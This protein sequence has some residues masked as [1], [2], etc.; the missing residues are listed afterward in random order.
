MVWSFTYEH[1]HVLPPITPHRTFDI[2][3]SFCP[4]SLTGSQ[5]WEPQPKQLA[6]HTGSDTSFSFFLKM[7]CV[8]SHPWAQ[9]I[10]FLH[11]FHKTLTLPWLGAPSSHTLLLC[12][13]QVFV[14]QSMW[15][16]LG[17]RSFFSTK[18]G[19]LW[20]FISPGW[21]QQSMRGIHAS[22]LVLSSHPDHS[23]LNT[24]ISCDGGGSG[25]RGS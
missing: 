20:L 22:T 24:R 11:L 21:A 2:C 7:P 8:F 5:G 17:A 6:T 1:N 13:P 10:P 3:I 14:L 15:V 9:A 18:T 12:C 4:L 23:L 19:F 16:A 25:D